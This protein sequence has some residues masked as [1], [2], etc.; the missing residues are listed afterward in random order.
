MTTEPEIK[1][2]P[3][4]SKAARALRWGRLLH[5]ALHL[6]WSVLVVAL[7]AM[8]YLW[9]I[10]LPEAWTTRLIAPFQTTDFRLAASR[11][12]VD[13]ID[14][15][16]FDGIR[17]SGPALLGTN[18]IRAGRM[19]VDF[20]RS[21]LRHGKVVPTRA[22]VSNGAI[23]WPYAVA[24]QSPTNLVAERL[25]LNLDMDDPNALEVLIT[26]FTLGVRVSV[27]GVVLRT[28]GPMAVS[29]WEWM[30]LIANRST[31]L[32]EI[33]TS[34]Q[35]EF[36]AAR[37]SDPPELSV[38]FKLDPAH[39]QAHAVSVE[40]KGG[41]A[42]FRGGVFDLWQVNMIYADGRIAVT[43]F[44]A[45]TARGGASGNAVFALA[46]NTFESHVNI[47]LPAAQALRILPEKTQLQLQAN[48]IRV[49]GNIEAALNVGPNAMTDAW[50][51][52]DGRF[53]AD[54]ALV[55]DAAFS[56]L[57]VEFAKTGSEVQV[58]S[59][60]AQVG[61]GQGSGPL[62]ADAQ[63][64]LTNAVIHANVKTAFDPGLLKSVLTTAQLHTAAFFNFTGA[65]PRVECAVDRTPSGDAEPWRVKGKIEARDFEFRGVPIDELTTSMDYAHD[66]LD[67]HDW[68]VV[69]PEGE[70]NG[71][72]GIEFSNEYFHVNMDST[73]DPNAVKKIIGPAFEHE[74]EIAHFNGPAHITASGMVDVAHSV[75]S[76]LDV[77]IDGKKLGIE[78]FT[79][80]EGRFDLSVRGRRYAFTN[81]VA[82]SCGGNLTGYFVMYPDTETP[83]FRYEVNA[84]VAGMELARLVKM[85]HAALSN[86]SRGAVSA[87]LQLAGLI[88][89]GQG[90][91]AVGTGSVAV[92]GGE[93][94]KVPVFGPLSTLLS[95]I[96]PGLGFASQSDFKSDFRV[97]RGR[98]RTDEAMLSGAIISIRFDGA[99]Y[100]D[101]RLK[102]VAAVK[103][104]R[105]GDIAS[106]VRW[107]TWPISKLF[108]FRLTGTI[109]DPEWRPNNLP[110]Q[111]FLIFD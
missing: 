62:L 36:D 26:G 87:S 11:V 44:V 103:P 56:D 67:M 32:P 108:E 86:E 101:G 33:L 40:M 98:I 66:R 71:Y 70:V 2:T 105:E 55:R 1:P 30:S 94:F 42:F 104:L 73:A 84:A 59:A 27:T 31:N 100:F 5:E 35:R 10:G 69:R 9:I 106:L 25:A 83:H 8:A 7:L 77:V 38:A 61:V 17:I 19:D 6:G 53:A 24:G 58:R 80:D 88:G 78:W 34:A 49:S 92:A 18:F 41:R 43:N 74:I 60:R 4:P 48:S 52:A 93:L 82:K 39:P 15:I 109:K 3:T 95:G 75:A 21:Q 99:Y 20:D 64:N 63:I 14:G 22:R 107:F 45:Q 68:R 54:R 47:R 23:V 79:A 51:R 90:V 102:F 16:V 97:S 72:L 65:P 12:R 111:M 81:V 29:P 37:F 13:P 89:E 28:D 46:P 85:S 50:G 91:T 110:K 76:D 57:A 96:S